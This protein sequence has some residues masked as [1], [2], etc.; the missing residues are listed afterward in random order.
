MRLLL[1]V[2]PRATN[3]TER[4]RATVVRLLG[5]RHQVEVATTLHRGH[6]IE[7]ARSAEGVDGIVVLAGDGTTNEAAAGIIARSAPTNDRD[8]GDRGT[9]P[10]LATLPGGGTNVLARTLG[11][12]HRVG[13]ATQALLASLDA[14]SIRRV[15]VGSI[16]SGSIG[17]GSTDSGST[18]SRVSLFHAG[19]GWDAELVSVV[20]AHSR[21]KRRI[22]HGLFVY[23]GLR[24]FFGGYDRR[25]P[26]FSVHFDDGEQIDDGYFSIVMNSDPYTYVGRRPFTIAPS[27]TLDGP[28]TVVV[29]RSMSVPHFLPLLVDALRDRRGV[30]E[31][32]WV[33]IRS[34]V[35]HVEYRALAAPLDGAVGTDSATSGLRRP[36][37]HQIDGDLMAPSDVLDVRHL[38]DVLDVVVP[39]P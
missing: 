3:V 33:R 39:L 19:I 6:A 34:G 12:P 16:G 13:A 26:H 27:T 29:L 25:H 20:E 2:N 8:G 7:L 1:I 38:P 36:L 23:A 22:G 37:L 5:E 9:T 21:W 15:G 24:T 31:R 28:L 14:G 4:H 18:D 30:R 32:P 35:E 17:S 11:V 10:W